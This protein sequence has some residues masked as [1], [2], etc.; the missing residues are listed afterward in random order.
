[1]ELTD[2]HRGL[3]ENAV[4][5]NPRFKGNEDLEEDFCSETFKRAYS[6]I[7]SLDEIR[8]F[9]LYI[10]KVA[11]SAI[12][13]VL[14][15]SGR[16]RK[17]NRKY[18]KNPTTSTDAYDFDD[19]GNITYDIADPSPS[20]EDDIIRQEEVKMV[21]DMILKLDAKDK[22]KRYFDIFVMRY[23]KGLNQSEVALEIGISQGEV[24]KRIT[25]LAKNINKC[26]K[27]LT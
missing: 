12:L 17:T 10:S 20:C 6:V 3:I 18:I 4:K 11:S 22:T 16:L 21:R 9:E 14:R 25:E 7:V 5:T 2:I 8:N 19:T 26:L 24:S 13:D 23:L 15:S 27:Q 1:V